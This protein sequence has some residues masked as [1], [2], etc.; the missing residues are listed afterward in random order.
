MGESPP[1]ERRGEILAGVRSCRSDV[2][3]LKRSL[4][5]ASEQRRGALDGARDAVD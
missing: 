1:A 4:V 2:A 5:V 3:S